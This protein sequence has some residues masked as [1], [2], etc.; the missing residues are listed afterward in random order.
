[1][2]EHRRPNPGLL[3]SLRPKNRYGCGKIFH[4][5]FK[6]PASWD[7]YFARPADP[8]PKNRPANGIPKT[9]HF[10]WGPVEEN[11]EAM[12][13][14]AVV[15][16]A[17]EKLNSQPADK[18]LFLAC[19]IYR[20]HL[21]WYAPRSDFEQ[22]PA[23]SVTLPKVLETDLDDVPPPGRRMA[24]PE[25]DHRKVTQHHQ[26]NEAVQGYLASI[27]FADRQVG[28]LLDALDQSPHADNTIVVL[29]GD[30]GWHLGEKLH[31]RKF[32][33]WE[34]ATRT[35]L[36][37]VAPGVTEADQQC[38]RT[39]SLVD[40]YPTLADLCGL[41][42]PGQLDGASLK[43]LLEDPSAAW[44]HP[45]LTTHGYK[46]HGLRNERW[47]YIRYANGD[48]ELYDHQQ[49]PLEWKNLA[50]DPQ[51][52]NVKKQLAQHLPEQDAPPVERK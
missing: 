25:G 41:P 50:D 5:R 35:P 52:V 37:M 13:D 12:G 2:K 40:I 33:L 10:D 47:R 42:V 51:Y 36:M 26:W 21:P 6:D 32:T 30:H 11:D 39:V 46:N 44:D 28:R 38:D 14:H 9:A 16:W 48:E 4:G 22:Y 17:I 29:W 18:A 3:L 24:N 45:A 20:P 27:A 43:S 34:E 23:A 7:E 15:D 49:D 19:G 8:A 1:M 31:W